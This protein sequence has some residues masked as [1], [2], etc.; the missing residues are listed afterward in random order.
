MTLPRDFKIE[1][2]IVVEFRYPEDG[3]GV[4]EWIE[5]G[6]P[7]ANIAEAKKQIEE[8]GKAGDYRMKRTSGILTLAPANH[9]VASI[10]GASESTASRHADADAESVL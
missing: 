3:E 4:N 5:L 6:S 2:E 9:M 7:C 10:S 8:F 1:D